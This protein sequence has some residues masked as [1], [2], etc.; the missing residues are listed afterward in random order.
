MLTQR[1]EIMFGPNGEVV[2]EA[3]GYVGNTCAEATK[4]V[5]DAL[6][7]SIVSNEKKPEYYQDIQGVLVSEGVGKPWCG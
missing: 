6:G 3:V 1:I 7:G 2:V 5:E 4:F